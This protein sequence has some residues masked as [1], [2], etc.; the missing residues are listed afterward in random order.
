MRV[1][2]N[3]HEALRQNDPSMP[4]G[5]QPV[6]KKAPPS[7]GRPKA[8]YSD[9]EPPS[10]GSTLVQPPPPLKP[11]PGEAQPQGLS[12]PLAAT[13]M[14][15]G[16]PPHPPVEALPRPMPMETSQGTNKH[17][18]EPPG[19]QGPAS[20]QVRHKP[21]P[22]AQPPPV[23]TSMASPSAV[24][25]PRPSAP[26]PKGPPA[27]YMPTPAEVTEMSSSSPAADAEE[28]VIAAGTGPYGHQQTLIGHV[29]SMSSLNPTSRESKEV[30]DV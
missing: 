18:L 30:H 22:F 25:M 28:S 12:L 19:Q 5:S 21:F 20:R 7:A 2:P 11:R 8:F 6:V 3:V 27:S 26:S 10:I 14:T 9:S 16:N 24:D 17:P 4:T 13:P 15:S 1:L 29:L 23:S